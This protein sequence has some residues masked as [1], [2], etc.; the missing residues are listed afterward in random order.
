M[1]LAGYKLL[2]NSHLNKFHLCCFDIGLFH[3]QYLEGTLYPYLLCKVP[4]HHI[5][6]DDLFHCHHHHINRYFL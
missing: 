5:V 1:E 2:K 6:L 3:M 4:V